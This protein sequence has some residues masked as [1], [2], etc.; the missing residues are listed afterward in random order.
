MFLLLGAEAIL[1]ARFGQGM[2]PIFLDE[3]DC[4]GT[5]LQLTSCRYPGVGAHNCGH[6]EDAGVVCGGKLA[7]S[8]KRATPPQS[9]G[10]LDNYNNVYTALDTNCR[11]GCA[12]E[13]YISDLYI[14][15]STF[16]WKEFATLKTDT[17]VSQKS[18]QPQ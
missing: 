4:N 11:Y 5:E 18:A 1:Q 8:I 15:S 2:G 16:I 9:I 17:V 10:P 7:I 3:V 13:F 6:F 14:A 12:D